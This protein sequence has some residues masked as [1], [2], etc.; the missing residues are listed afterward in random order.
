MQG[1]ISEW[2]SCRDLNRLSTAE[3][4]RIKAGN[5]GMTAGMVMTAGMLNGHDCWQGMTA[6][7]VIVHDCWHRG[8]VV[9]H[10]FMMIAMAIYNVKDK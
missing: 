9:G 8:M 5:I 2:V 1:R 10:D 3:Q 7:M 4:E 6:G